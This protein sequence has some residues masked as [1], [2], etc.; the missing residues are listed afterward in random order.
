M[1]HRKDDNAIDDVLEAL[2]ANGLEGINE[3]MKIERS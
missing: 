3:A 2:I 1:T